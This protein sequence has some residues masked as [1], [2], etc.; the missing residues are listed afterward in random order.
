MIEVRQTVVFER[1][2]RELRDVQAK[3]RINAFIRRVSLGVI[4]DVK[5]VDDGVG[6]F[7]ID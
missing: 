2:M 4:G 5:S 1:W 3:A 6:E 7:R